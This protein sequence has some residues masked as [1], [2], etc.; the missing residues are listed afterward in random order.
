MSAVKEPTDSTQPAGGVHNG[1]GDA[2][3]SRDGSENIQT[4][5]ED[6]TSAAGV[7]PAQEDDLAALL[8]FAEQKNAHI[9]VEVLTERLPAAVQRHLATALLPLS[10]AV[11]ALLAWRTGQEALAKY[12][13]KAAVVQGEETLLVWPTYFVLPLGCA[14]MALVVLGRFVARIFPPGGSACA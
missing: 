5:A 1:A 9:A 4:Q 8:A 14:L 13:I 12:A 6:D 7:E 2:T 11:F 3:V 10:A